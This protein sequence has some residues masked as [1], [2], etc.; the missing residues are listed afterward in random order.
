MDHLTRGSCNKN[1]SCWSFAHPWWSDSLS[2]GHG[3]TYICR[4]LAAWPI[5]RQFENLNFSCA[6]VLSFGKLPYA[7]T[8][9]ELCAV[10]VGR[11]QQLSCPPP[12]AGP[13]DDHNSFMSQ[14]L[15]C[16]PWNG[17]HSLEMPICIFDNSPCPLESIGEIWDQPFEA[18]W[19]PALRFY[20][21]PA[22]EWKRISSSRDVAPWGTAGCAIISSQKF[23]CFDDIWGFQQ[24]CTTSDDWNAT[25]SPMLTG[26]VFNFVH[27]KETL[28][29]ALWPTLL[30]IFAVLRP[31][32]YH[33]YLI[34]DKNENNN[35]SLAFSLKYECQPSLY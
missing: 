30:M 8:L 23:G 27:N 28:Y 21:D 32:N 4:L 12:P 29:I 19:R 14:R 26:L 10:G 22:C 1:L 20:S 33:W 25:A 2:N 16:S 6:G 13:R 34:G 11:S 31:R 7:P 18:I 3:H 24:L 35:T 15:K 5:F 17:D 9:P